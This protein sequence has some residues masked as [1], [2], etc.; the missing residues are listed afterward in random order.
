MNCDC[1]HCE[2]LRCDYSNK[3]VFMEKIYD[4]LMDYGFGERMSPEKNQ[5]YLSVR[6]VIKLRFSINLGYNR[7]SDEELGVALQALD[8]ILP[9]LKES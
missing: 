2:R 4:R 7:M 9:S 1:C 6:V 5:A 8:E 3:R